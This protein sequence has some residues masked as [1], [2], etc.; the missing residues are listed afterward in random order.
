MLAGFGDDILGVRGLLLLS[1]DGR[2]AF[3]LRLGEALYEENSR[4]M[5]HPYACHLSQCLLHFPIH[6]QVHIDG[7]V[8]HNQV[9]GRTSAREKFEE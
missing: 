3:H 1:I 7:A 5:L 2:R 4:E 8:N 9:G 6:I